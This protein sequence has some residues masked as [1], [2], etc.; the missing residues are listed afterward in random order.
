MR[1]QFCQ[2]YKGYTL[3]ELMASV[4]I[5]GVLTT[6]A[7]PN[8]LGTLQS[9]RQDEAESTLN[10]LMM[11][12]AA[13]NDEYSRPAEGWSDLDEIAS[14][15]TTTGTASGSNF[16]SIVLQG[17]HYA[18]SGS[19]SGN[20][21]TFEVKPIEIKSQSQNSVGCINVATGESQIISGNKKLAASKTSLVCST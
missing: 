18:A 2:Q 19:R 8:Y 16:S 13:F 14:I 12:A 11:H 17:G 20:R 15:M 10:Q 7:I 6:I 3:T 21:Y 1:Q 9:T 5:L 4:A